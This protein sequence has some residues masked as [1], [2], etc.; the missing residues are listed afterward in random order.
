M[1]IQK[2]FLYKKRQNYLKKKYGNKVYLKM[3]T[4]FEL[5]KYKKNFG[6]LSDYVLDL[7]IS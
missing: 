5:I 7:L 1:Y 6:R 3:F 2:N 4:I